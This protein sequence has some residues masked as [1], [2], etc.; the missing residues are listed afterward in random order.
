VSANAMPVKGEHE[1]YCC[2]ARLRISD[3]GVEILSKPTVEYRPLHETV[4]GTKKL[5]LRLCEK[6]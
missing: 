5:M 6:C 2:S 3:K 4:Y 1:I